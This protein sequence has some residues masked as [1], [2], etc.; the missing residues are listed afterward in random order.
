VHQDDSVYTTGQDLIMGFG[1]FDGDQAEEVLTTSINDG[2]K[3]LKFRDGKPEILAGIPNG[4][5]IGGWTFNHLESRFAGIGDVNGDGKAEILLTGDQGICVLALSAAGRLEPI[6]CKPSDTWFGGWRFNSGA[7]RIEGLGDFDGDGALEVLISS[8]W[9]IGMLK[10]SGDTFVAYFAHPT[11]SWFG[12]WQYDREHNQIAGLG[13]F[14][15]ATG[16]GHALDE[17]LISSAWGIGVLNLSADTLT[18]E[19]R[20][21]QP[22]GRRFGSWRYDA[23]ADQVK[24]IADFNG[25][26]RDEILLANQNSIGLISLS[27]VSFDCLDQQPFGRLIGNW[28]LEANDRLA[29]DRA[30]T[31]R[32]KHHILIQAALG[33]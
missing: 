26:D 19:S 7:D 6:V 9:G 18:L 21:L 14:S 4:T 12:G 2:I 15:G 8:G 25:D 5:S 13:R 11:G 29:P 17:I 23:Y 27:G 24:A 28:K 33:G 30:L 20:A 16:A 32:R 10:Q 1:D 3:I 31:P 22:G